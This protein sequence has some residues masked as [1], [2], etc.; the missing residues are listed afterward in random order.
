MCPAFEGPKELGSW[1]RLYVHNL[2]VDYRAHTHT[3]TH[4]FLTPLTFRFTEKATLGVNQR[5]MPVHNKTYRGRDFKK[6][7]LVLE[8]DGRHKSDA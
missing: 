7:S 6:H 1:G 5:Y 4:I 2:Y 8:L 3:H